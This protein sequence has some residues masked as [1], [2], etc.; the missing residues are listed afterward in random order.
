MISAS[1]YPYTVKKIQL[2]SG[3]NLAYIDEGQG[4]R[5]LVFV[6]G[7]GAY[8]LCWK[9]NIE[10]LKNYYRCIAI[11]LPGNGLSDHGDYLYSMS[12]F[13]E[14]V[15]DFINRL[16]LKNV[17]LAGHS[18][19]GQ[20][21]IIAVLQHAN[22]VEDLILCA[23]AGFEIFTAS[24]KQLYQAALN[25]L[26]HF[27]NEESKLQQIMKTCFYRNPSQANEMIT[28]LV[29]IMQTYP[30][31]AYKKM[32]EGCVNGMLDEPVLE[33]LHLIKQRTLIL[34]GEHDA[35]IPNK[36]LHH[37]TTRKIAEHAVAQMPNATL[38]MIPEAGH[39]LQWEKADAV[40]SAIKGFLS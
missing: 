3:C 21:S 15:Y 30:V 20:T 18:M 11:D 34:F 16:G 28:D 31:N 13:A 1:Y 17:C 35:V 8:A 25:L 14:S 9:K 36:L 12:F 4:D 37:T 29:A 26:D 40:N 2:S 38:Q 19:G 33:K 39:F 22:F 24:E 10:Y 27:S 7:L 32:I 23:P 5:T 6:H